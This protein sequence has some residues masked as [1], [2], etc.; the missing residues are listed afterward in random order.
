M[1]MMVMRRVQ[2]IGRA[3]WGALEVVGWVEKYLG[4]IL[5]ELPFAVL[6]AIPG[7]VKW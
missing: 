1:A 6:L 4:D 3:G 2:Q 5:S 7:V